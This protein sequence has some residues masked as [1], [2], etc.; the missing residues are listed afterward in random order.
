MNETS[1]Q[2]W[3]PPRFVPAVVTE[4]AGPGLQVETAI[5]LKE[6]ERVLVVFEPVQGRVMQ[7]LGI[8]RRILESDGQGVCAAIELVGLR[9]AG[10][11]ELVRATN[12]AARMVQEAVGANQELL[13]GLGTGGWVQVGE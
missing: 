3:A 8:V 9:D 4:M 2:T 1:G 5:R 11:S 10:I 12:A 7:D 13:A 6:K